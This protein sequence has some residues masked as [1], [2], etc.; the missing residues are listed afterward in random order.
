[1]RRNWAKV[2]REPALGCWLVSCSRVSALLGKEW[3][4]AANE[5]RGGD[6]PA[7]A[8]ED[9][10]EGGCP[11]GQH[12]QRSH[13]RANKTAHPSIAHPPSQARTRG[14]MSRG[15]L[16]HAGRIAMGWVFTETTAT[17]KIGGIVMCIVSELSVGA[18]TTAHTK[19]GIN[20]G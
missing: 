19:P 5:E 10:R 12:R 15:T 8:T 7:A 6:V 13:R 9:E 18:T 1:M 17:Q 3:L 16:S 4:S 20:R 11:I 2:M 14:V